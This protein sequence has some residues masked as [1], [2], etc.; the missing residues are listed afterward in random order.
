MHGARR[1]GFDR[2]VDKERAAR[3]QRRREGQKNGARVG[4]VLQDVDR[5]DE[6]EGG[7]GQLLRPH[8]EE[9]G[10]QATPLETPAGVVVEGRV[11]L[12]E[13]H[14]QTVPVEEEPERA[15]AAPEVQV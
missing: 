14:V 13:R 1:V 5:G 15:Y 11:D 12:A 4:D 7:F 6:V 10:R 9:T 2:Q 3:A 8:V